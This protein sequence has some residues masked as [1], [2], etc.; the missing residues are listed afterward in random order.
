MRL[1]L[2]RSVLAGLLLMLVAPAA[3]QASVGVGVQAGPVRLSGA[4]H[5]GGSYALP[6]LLVVNTG[7][8]ME[9]VAIRIERLSSGSGRSIPPGWIHVTGPAVT[10]GGGQSGRIQL[11]LVVPESAKPGQYFSDVVAKGSAQTSAGGAN[12]GVAAATDLEFGVAPGVVSGPWLTVPG[13]LLPLAAV[14]IALALLIIFVRRSGLRIR[15]ERVRPNRALAVLLAV[16]PMAAAAC[17]VSA[18]PAQS[19]GQGTNLS[20]TLNTVKTI[21][22]VTITPDKATFGKCSGGSP[23]NNT[24]SQAGALGFPN[25]QCLV[26]SLGQGASYPITIRNSGIASYMDVNGSSASPSDGDSQWNLCNRGRNPAVSCNR[27][28]GNYHMP[29][30]NQYLLQNFSGNGVNSSGLTDNP[31]CDHEFGPGGQCWAMQNAATRE[32]FE[33]IGPY[34]ST[35]TSTKWTVTITWTPIPR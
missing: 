26:G 23:G 3:A 1:R 4:A 6:A 12:I 33:L 16:L 8:E 17:G 22:S 29:G 31:V 27:R 28:S 25:G 24:G 13:W 32:G 7:T 10:L 9:S 18:A 5:P 35:D 14:L 15:I 21:R 20:L 34:F 19:S 11:E 2:F 30:A